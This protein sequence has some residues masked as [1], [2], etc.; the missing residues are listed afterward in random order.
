MPALTPSQT[1]GPFFIE[2]VRWAIQS[3]GTPPDGVPV[4][5]RVLDRDGKGVSDALLEI[6]QPGWQTQLGGLQRAATDDEGRFAFVMPKP[7]SGQVQANV[8]VFARGLLQGLFTRVY[9]HPGDDV[10]AVALP[11]GVPEKRRATLV[12]RRTDAGSYR[13]DV[14]LQGEGETVF[15]EI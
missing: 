15:F 9:L 3:A 6:W 11:K 4:T 2:A 10:A 14:R 1:I 8:T 12:A 5:G 7:R 13:W